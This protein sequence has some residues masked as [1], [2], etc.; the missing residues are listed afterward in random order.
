MA[1][2]LKTLRP[3]FWLLFFGSLQRLF[4]FILCTSRIENSS[5]VIYALLLGIIFDLN[6]LGIL[7]LIY[8]LLE[9]LNKK[10]SE[11]IFLLFIYIWI[12]L[13][14]SDLI[15]FYY[16][17]IRCSANSFQLFSVNDLFDK[18]SDSGIVIKALVLLAVFIIALLKLKKYILPNFTSFK[19]KQKL[20]LACLFFI[21]SLTYLPYPINYYTYQV[22][23][24]HNAKQL[25]LN[26]YYSWSKSFLHKQNEYIMDQQEALVS[27]KTQQGYSNTT[28]FIE[29]EVNY[30][31]TAYDNVVLIIM[32]SFGANRIGILNGD[33][34][35]SP[36]FDSLCAEGTLYTKCFASGPRTQYGISSILFG[37]P[38]ILG[39]NLFRENKLK[40]AFNG[41]LHLSEKNNYKTHFIHGGSAAYDDME[42][43]LNGD[44]A[45]AV[46]DVEDIK[47][48][49][50]RNTWGVDDEALFNF[51]EKYI[52]AN[53]GKNLFCI[54]SMSNHEP[55]QLPT[56]FKAADGI[57]DL[58]K[59]EKT[60]L[61][62]D[63]ALG[64]FIQKL[65]RSKKY[66]R[67]LIIVTGDHAESYS[68]RDNETKLF[69]V[70]LL[71]IDHQNKNSK[72][73]KICAHADIAEFIL[74]KTNYKGKSHFISNNLNNTQPGKTY[75]RNYNNDIYKVTD[76]LIY[77]YNLVDRSFC[78][79]HVDANMYV[80]TQEIVKDPDQVNKEIIEDIKS[81]YTSLQYLFENGM[82][83]TN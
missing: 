61:Y 10:I 63:M 71:I 78:K 12:I 81:Y 44:A 3:F 9:D 36:H 29:R 49:K 57:K 79:I 45:L 25:S 24:S 76:S 72:N 13:N 21:L 70:P 33:K 16:I 5:E 82:Y 22:N 28:S 14:V 23:I 32:E 19:I 39:Y 65:K 58:D 35:L 1:A 41:V 83:H 42:L 43:F 54:L 77:R 26:S 8:L 18:M 50:F 40:H 53:S 80:A 4:I 68:P 62:S 17:G 31:D 20:L 30:T 27:F 60:F 73:N 2:I 51:S 59:K 7:F 37:F 48:F 66:D 74:S 38:H 75:Y 64:M 52:A 46:K 6:F 11:F 47:D 69:H 67:T 15:S 56:D 34:A 55:H